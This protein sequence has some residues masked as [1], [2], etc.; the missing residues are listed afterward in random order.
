MFDIGFT[1]L[2][3]CAVIALLVLGPERLPQAARTAGRWA[4]KARRMVQQMSDE[5]DRQVK[6]DE[7]RERIKDESENLGLNE[8]QDSVRSALDN[9]AEVNSV[10]MPPD[11]E[12]E[13]A[14]PKQH[15]PESSQTQS[16]TGAEAT[17]TGAAA[18]A[19]PVA[20]EPDKQAPR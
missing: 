14:A 12:S 20:G 3:V 8:V 6:A 13:P 5:I 15:E 9:A 16:R 17:E 7:L 1:E 19:E 2:L 10:I 11:E 18:S 4:G